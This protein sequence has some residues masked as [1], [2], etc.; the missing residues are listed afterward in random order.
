MRTMGARARR[1]IAALEAEVARLQSLVD[2]GVGLAR[3]GHAMELTVARLGAE[4]PRRS[5]NSELV[6]WAVYESVLGEL[7]E[8]GFTADQ[9]SR[10]A[11]EITDC[12]DPH[13]AMC[14]MREAYAAVS[15]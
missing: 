15:P 13:G 11:R 6:D 7:V 14:A 4:T 3:L 2:A 8:M 9:S 12:G 1:K 5:P 10:F